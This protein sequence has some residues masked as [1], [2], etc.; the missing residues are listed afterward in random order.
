MTTNGNS[1]RIKQKALLYVFAKRNKHSIVDVTEDGRDLIRVRYEDPID[2][3]VYYTKVFERDRKLDE[4][5]HAA[6]LDLQWR[7]SGM[8]FPEPVVL[9]QQPNPSTL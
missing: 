8:E 9:T 3:G 1:E 6:I 7:A 2:H 4:E 5:I